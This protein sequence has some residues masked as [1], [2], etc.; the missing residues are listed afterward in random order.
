MDRAD[1]P[2]M[3]RALAG[4]VD[5]VTGRSV[6]YIDG[7]PSAVRLFRLPLLREM[8]E[9]GHRVTVCGPRADRITVEAVLAAGA[10]WHELSL[11]RTSLDPIADLTATFGIVRML[12]DFRPDLVLL[13][14]MKAV[15]YGSLAA[16][17][18]KVP[19]ICSMITGLGFAFG[20]GGLKRRVLSH[21]VRYLCRRALAANA[22]VVFQ[23]RDDRDLLIKL[24]IIPDPQKTIVVAGSGIELDRF[25][26]CPLP[27]H[28]SFLML[29]RLIGDKGVREYASAARMLRNT[30]PSVRWRLAG[31]FDAAPGAIRSSEIADWVNTGDIEYLGY[32][33]DVRPAIADA[34]IVVLPSYYREGVPH[35]LLE[36]L[37]MGRPLITTNMPGCRDTVSPD[38]NGIIVPPRDSVALATA[39]ARLIGEPARLPE[40]GQ[41]SRRL[42]KSKFDVREVNRAILTALDL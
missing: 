29:A 14:T 23:N 28:T 5:H 19:R 8:A 38:V 18:A 16:R 2:G 39:M 33:E 11:S 30:Y 10:T 20:E 37:A 1:V 24:G 26:F 35:S 42:A 22:R 27:S 40:M 9:R 3:A 34:S 31:A 17:F 6:V 7:H 36:G 41:E 4:D 21:G 15:A 12:Q 25:R 32:L 13:R